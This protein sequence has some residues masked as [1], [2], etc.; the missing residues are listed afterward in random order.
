[1]LFSD[2]LD[3]AEILADRILKQLRRTFTAWPMPIIKT[4]NSAK[5]KSTDN[6]TISDHLL[7]PKA[8]MYLNLS[9][10]FGLFLTFTTNTR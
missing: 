4:F 6:V 7:K 5:M 3:P 9:S 2:L 1:M 8:C 10:A